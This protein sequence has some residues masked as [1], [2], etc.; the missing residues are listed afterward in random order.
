MSMSAY[1]QTPRVESINV[2]EYGIYTTTTESERAAKDT[3]GGAIKSTTNIRHALTT[4]D[5]PAQLGL[6]FGFRFD[7]I[8]TPTG[9]RV[10]VH[11]VAI[12]PAPGLYDTASKQ[13]FPKA[14]YDRIDAIGRGGYLSYTFEQDWEQIPGVWTFQLWN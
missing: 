5:I 3:P 14:E 2:V 6:E 11:V 10:P 7:V 12:F 13:R 4:R 9:A 8:G 1:G